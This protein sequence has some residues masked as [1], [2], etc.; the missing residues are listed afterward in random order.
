MANSSN[1]KENWLFDFYNQDSYLSFDGT[2]DYIDCGTTTQNSPVAVSGSGT[3]AFWIRFPT[4]T[5]GQGEFIFANNMVESNY[6]GIWINKTG[7]HKIQVHIMDGAGTGS[8]DR[9]TFL[10]GTVLQ[11]NVWYLIVIASNFDHDD[12]DPAIINNNWK[13]YVNNDA[14]GLV[15]NSGTASINA[16]SYTTG[17]CEFGRETQGSDSYG[18]FDL[19]NFAVWKT[20][21]TSSNITALYNS[22]YY[23]NLTNID[24]DNI[25]AYWKFNND[26]VVT[27][28]ING[29]NGKIYG[30]SYNGSALH[31]SF[32]DTEY[33]NQFYYGAILNRPSIRESIDLSKSN[34]KKSNL[35]IEIP[36]FEYN[37]S[38][39][40]EELF[41]SS[42]YLN[43]NV[44]VYSKI[45]SDTP[46]LIGCFRLA[47]ISTDGSTLNLELNSFDPWDDVTFPQEKHTQYGVY[48]PTVY[49]DYAHGTFGGDGAYVSVYP[50]PVLYAN[51]NLL[52]CVY[53]RAYDAGSNH[54]LHHNVGF[55]W[56]T[57][58]SDGS[59]NA[60]SEAPATVTDGGIDV[61]HSPTTRTAKGYIRSANSIYE[62][63][64]SGTATY[65]TNPENI[66]KY[67][68]FDG[69]AYASSSDSTTYGTADVNNADENK[70]LVIQTPK[71]TYEVTLIKGIKVKHSIMWDDGA[72]D[73]QEYDIDFFTNE[74]HSSNDDLLSSP[75]TQNLASNISTHTFTF[76][77]SPA[78]A[79]SGKGSSSLCPDEILMKWN[80]QHNA[81]TYDHED[82]ELRVYD[83]QMLSL[84]EFDYN[85][86][87]NKQLAKEKHFYCGGDGLQHGITGLLGNS[88]TE[89]HE[90]HLDLMNRFANFDVKTSPAT[91]IIGWGNGSSDNKLDHTKAWKIRYWE[92]EPVSLLKSLEKLQ[93]EGGFIF[94]FRRGDLTQPEYIFIKNSYASTDIDF[95]NISKFDLSSVD[96]QP[97]SIKSITTKLDINYK[98]HPDPSSNKY[99]V[100]KNCSNNVSKSEYIINSKE[101]KKSI[102]LDTYVAPEIPAKP[103]STPNNDFYSYY[104]NIDGKLRIKITSNM[105]NP[106]YFDI[107]VGNTMTFTNMYPKKLFNKDYTNVVFMITSIT[108]TMGS[109]KFTAEEIATIT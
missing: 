58:I 77:E 8:G 92:L 51:N 53:P 48:Q 70:Y 84:T 17:K 85:D 13:I 19:R 24:S 20:F 5:N 94:R 86:D 44:K 36:D 52:T 82:H 65:L 30:A 57:A 91:D 40:S 90:A 54:Y 39:I 31:L 1:I 6:S 81:P 89:I 56:F 7:E 96:I 3:F 109:L 99:V 60:N 4:L 104:N 10:S 95:P 83:I 16:P 23:T 71:K 62:A 35:S 12:S 105:I 106:K 25:V 103:S 68:S 37:D 72:G 21:L 28:F 22:G 102:N 34:A 107:N 88:I 42:V 46:L 27:D 14:S 93:Y 15:T 29:Q 43:Y 98:K 61:F 79:L 55:N 76:N 2:D 32:N 41:G 9:E 47:D 80:P 26:V 100:L 11:E 74:Y 67:N 50:V 97:S 64:D 49:G 69:S 75:Q 33:N 73:N 101:N 63:S 59:G 87:D 78:N 18:K 45:D 38:L 66:F 108:R